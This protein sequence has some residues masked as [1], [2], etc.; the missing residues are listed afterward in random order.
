RFN[1]DGGFEG[2]YCISFVAAGSWID[3]DAD[4]GSNVLIHYVIQDEQYSQYTPETNVLKFVGSAGLGG[5]FTDGDWTVSVKEIQGG[6][7]TVEL[8]FDCETCGTDTPAAGCSSTDTLSDGDVDGDKCDSYRIGTT[9]C[10]QFD[11]DNFKSNEMCCNC[12]GG[13]ISDGATQVPSMA[14]TGSPI[15]QPPVSSGAPTEDTINTETDTDTDTDTAATT[16]D[17]D[18]ANATTENTN[19]DT[20]TKDSAFVVKTTDVEMYSKMALARPWKWRVSGLSGALPETV[21]RMQ[22]ATC[23]DKLFVGWTAHESWSPNEEFPDQN[24]FVENTVGHLSEY[25]IDPSTGIATLVS[26]QGFEYCNEMGD[27]TVSSDCSVKAVLCRSSLEPDEISGATDWMASVDPNRVQ[28]GWYQ[29]SIPLGESKYRTIDQMYLM[30]WT[31]GAVVANPPSHVALVSHSQGGWNYGH[32]SLSLNSG[33]TTYSVDLK[34]TIT[35]ENDGGWHEGSTAF[36]IDRP[37]SAGKWNA[38]LS[39]GWGCAVGHTMGNRLTYNENLDKWARFCWTDG[40]NSQGKPDSFESSQGCFGTFFATIP[41]AEP[42]QSRQLM[43]LEYGAPAGKF[44]PW[45]GNGGPGNLISRGDDGFLGI[46]VRPDPKVPS[47]LTIGLAA[48]PADQAGCANSSCG[49]SWIPASVLG[50]SNVY[51]YENGEEGNA[52]GLANIQHI[53]PGGDEGKR[54]LLGFADA[55]EFKGISSQYYVVEADDKGSLYGDVTPIDSGWGEEDAWLQTES[56]CVVFP[57]AWAGDRGPG[58]TYGNTKGNDEENMSSIMRVTVI[59][60]NGSKQ[61]KSFDIDTVSFDDDEGGDTTGIIVGAAVGGGI[62]LVTAAGIGVRNWFNSRP[63]SE[64]AFDQQPLSPPSI[65]VKRNPL[66]PGLVSR[67]QAYV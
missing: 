49:F 7:A 34:T 36:A 14:P 38:E 22:S 51:Y 2:I 1:Q 9:W 26:D 6:V 33:K 61:D 55:V 4:F 19:I 32:Y 58:S 46:A 65:K 43:W 63:V 67:V 42:E 28:F 52:L 25:D 59:C 17:T 44:D 23:G 50:G 12:G 39:S 11:D 18:N 8:S 56:G 66:S 40:C 16:A 3:D 60:H 35:S 37:I 53:G 41:K 30:E 62:V 10:G 45:R 47:K 27:V 13:I 15:T 21:R 29:T 31:E 24:L 57:F 64:R 54:Y 48:L 5:S 20:S